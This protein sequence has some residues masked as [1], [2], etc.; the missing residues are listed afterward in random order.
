MMHK[1]KF[2]LE[3]AES[4][5]WEYAADSSRVLIPLHALPGPSELVMLLQAWW[6]ELRYALAWPD[7][8]A[9]GFKS[10][11][12]FEAFVHEGERLGLLLDRAL[13]VEASIDIDLTSPRYVRSMAPRLTR[14]R[15]FPEWATE[16]P[17]WNGVPGTG[18]YN[19]MLTHL[20][21]SPELADALRE[22]QRKF[23]ATYN[24]EDPRESGFRT[25]EDSQQFW[26]EGAG[27]AQWFAREIGPEAEVVWD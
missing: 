13:G 3:S 8:L 18:P 4:P 11:E 20:P 9:R 6:S 12:A 14:Y 22:W 17:V 24:A 7:P 16:S 25:D 27:L 1:Y 2:S 10:D 21:I 19:L 5:I 23:L 15:I 26:R